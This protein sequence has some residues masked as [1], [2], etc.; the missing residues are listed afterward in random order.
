MVA[1]QFSN[2]RGL[3]S[4]LD[5]RVVDVGSGQTDDVEEFR[6]EPEAIGG[7]VEEG[8]NVGGYLNLTFSLRRE[9]ASNSLIRTHLV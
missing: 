8:T 3:W 6:H 2:N 4:E 1:I 5:R 9:L 7:G